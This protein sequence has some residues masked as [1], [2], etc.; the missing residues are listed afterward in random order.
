MSKESEEN[1]EKFRTMCQ[2]SIELLINAGMIATISQDW[3]PAVQ[4]SFGER[5]ENV[6]RELQREMGEFQDFAEFYDA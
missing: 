3:P 5:I 1:A 2:A 4:Q 6:T